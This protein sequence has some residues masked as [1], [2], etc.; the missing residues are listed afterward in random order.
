MAGGDPPGRGGGRGIRHLRLFWLFLKLSLQDDAAYRG[1]F[2]TR[3][4]MTLY[5][6]AGVA[7]GLWILFSNTDT[8]AGWTLD[9]VIVLIG[10]YHVVSGVVRA[11]FSPN[12]Q[13]VVEEVREGTLDFLLT[14]PGNSQFLASFRRI[15]VA[16]L[17]ESLL[18]LAVILVG[19]ARLWDEVGAG[20]LLTFLFALAC[21]LTVL[22]AFW[23]CIITL[24]FWFVRIEN[25]TQIFWSLFEAG[26]YPLD[27]YPGWLRA[28]V[29]YI[30]PVAIVTTVPARG[31]MGSLSPL[32]LA[33]FSLAALLA[34]AAA[35]RFWRYGIRSYTSASS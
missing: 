5:S 31:L 35:A 34:L 11:V 2:W 17:G 28:L 4:F 21:G 9:Q 8:L 12:L 20:A 27:I 3:L 32:T 6:L 23:L 10:T 13:R 22:Y 24:V 29:S 14:K 30:I 26:R 1:E 15:A 7:A 19:F 16:A 18:G 25:V 33:G